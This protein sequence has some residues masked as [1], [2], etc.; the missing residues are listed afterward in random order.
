MNSKTKI[1]TNKIVKY[2]REISVVVIGVAITLSVTLW[3]SRKSEK[4]DLNLYLNAVKMEMEENINV[5]NNYIKFTRFEIKYSN[6]L[7]SID[8]KSLNVDTLFYYV[9]NCFSNQIFSFK[10]Y[11]FEMF[12]TSGN[13]RLIED[14]ELLLTL[15]RVYD[16]LSMLTKI[17][18]DYSQIKLEEMKKD[19]LLFDINNFTPETFKN[20]TPMY[21][22]YTLGYVNCFGWTESIPNDTK[23]AFEM[24]NKYCKE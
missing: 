12:R 19:L 6:Y 7:L 13:M 22:F 8:R 4:R 15:W 18:D 5:L 16:N 17:L 20:I 3:I 24:L 9:E 21:N 10:T 11:A 23:E 2:L 1:S 14:K